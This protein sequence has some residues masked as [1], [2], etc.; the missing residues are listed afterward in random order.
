MRS[1]RSARDIARCLEVD[2]P[3]DPAYRHKVVLLELLFAV[4]RYCGRPEDPE[5]T[6]RACRSVMAAKGRLAA[7]FPFVP[8]F[9]VGLAWSHHH[10]SGILRSLARPAEAETEDRRAVE[11]FEAVIQE[12]P[13]VEPYRRLMASVC[14]RLGQTL[15][16]TG[17]HREA[18]PYLRR[19]VELVPESVALRERVERLLASRGT[20]MDT[21]APTDA[22]RP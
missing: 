1:M 2:F 21:E 19:A 22:R 9:R 17:R 3:N 18:V 6:L 15:A 5:E 14:E 11:L 7:D 12:H 4:P 13:T 8:D 20:L 16:A 10:F